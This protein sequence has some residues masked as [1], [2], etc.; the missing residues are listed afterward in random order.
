MKLARSIGLILMFL[1]CDSPRLFCQEN[2]FLK[3]S[4]T[5]QVKDSQIKGIESEIVSMNLVNSLSL[6]PQQA[7]FILEQARNLKALY[8]QCY[9]KSLE[10][11]P[12][13]LAVY[14]KIKEQLE[15]GK[16][17]WATELHRQWDAYSSLIEDLSVQMQV[18]IEEAVQKVEGQLEDFQLRALDGFS[19]CIMPSYNQGFIGQSPKGSYCLNILEKIKYMPEA[20]YASQK[21]LLVQEE[22]DKI[23]YSGG[24]RDNNCEHFNRRARKK[25]IL[26]AAEEARKMDNVNFELKK[27]ELARKLKDKLIITP[28]LRTRKQRVIE[29]LLSEQA[30]SILEKKASKIKP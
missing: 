2:S 26:S 21:Q 3:L 11:K 6:R 22:L 25:D 14:A 8:G 13:L 16:P 28:A 30:I 12:N 19:D 7:E 1:G 5:I 9:N 10:I 20:I 15:L 17:V 4:E 24:Y 23:K 18:A 29:L 27:E